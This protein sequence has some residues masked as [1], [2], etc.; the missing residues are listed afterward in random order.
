MA[1]RNTADLTSNDQQKTAPGVSWEALT[2]LRADM[3]RFAELQLRNRETAED[4]VQEAIEAALRRSSSFAGHST[5]KTWVFAILRNRI[6]D[7]LRQADR[8]VNLSSL[9][10]EDEDLEQRLEVLF[11]EGGKWK[12]GHRPA[13]WPNPEQ[14]LQSQQFWNV[15]EACLTVLPAK[16]SRVFMMR[17][18]LGFEAE[19]ICTQLGITMSNC[20][21]ILHR[22]RLKLRE[23][24]DVGWGRKEAP[25]C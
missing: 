6:I 10:K 20:H 14:A 24:M 2:A 8:C 15:F 18:F 17:E 13:T 22:A 23:C 4:L 19:E 3:L 12:D 9:V 21:V 7:H 16:T 1:R 11:N 25:V 5:L